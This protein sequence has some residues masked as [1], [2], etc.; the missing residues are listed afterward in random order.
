MSAVAVLF[1]RSDSIYKT[2]P[3]C[4][5]FDLARDARTYD[6]D[7][8][9]VAHPPCR[10]WGR[11]SH[12]AKPRSD[13]RDLGIFAVR[14]VRRTGGVLEHPAAS[15]LW[16][17]AGLPAP[18]RRDEF[19]GYTL[20]VYQGHFGHLAPK[21]TWLYVVGVEPSALPSLPFELSLPPGRIELMGKAAREHTPPAF[22]AFLV[23]VASRVRQ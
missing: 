22:A 10:A 7:L 20:P 17:A 9:V 5:V 8:P 12:M 15:K 3:L 14:T 18:G 19:G 11:L 13:E 6:G 23:D 1:A 21:A 4:D 16:P 2:L